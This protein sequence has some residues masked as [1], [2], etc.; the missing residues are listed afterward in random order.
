ML[1]I[2][3]RLFPQK[4]KK[5]NAKKHDKKQKKKQDQ[6]STFI[7]DKA[8]AD[9]EKDELS[10]K[11]LTVAET[12]KA[13]FTVFSGHLR[14]KLARIHITV[15][16]SDAAK[17]AILYGVVSGA[18]ACLVDLLDEITNL[19]RIQKSSILIEPDF[20]SEKSNISI[21]ITLSISVFG[22]LRTLVKTLFRYI[23]LKY[24]KPKGN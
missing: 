18:A 16:T 11:I 12:V 23:R 22:A 7:K 10:S 4:N 1:F 3:I 5:F 14:V 21:N 19:S 24:I 13:F 8:L 9:K 15:A 17:T 6:P 2:K 20:V